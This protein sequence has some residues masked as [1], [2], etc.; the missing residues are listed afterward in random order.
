MTKQWVQQER[1]A[2]FMVKLM[3]WLAFKLGRGGVRWILYPT[4]LYFLLTAPRSVRASRRCLNRLLGRRATLLDV[5]RH[6]F[7]FSSCT[8][9]RIFLLSN[10]LSAFTVE[11][12]SSPGMQETIA[13]TPGCLLIVA[14]F[15]ST[16][17]LR[18]APLKTSVYC[19]P[20]SVAH[21]DQSSASTVESLQVSVLIDK[22]S[23]PQITAQLEA[24]NPA[25]A[26]NLI[27]ASERGPPLVLKLKEALEAGRLVGIAADR[28]N[29]GERAFD[30]QFMGGTA[31]MPDG[32]WVLAAALRVPVILGFGIY[33]GGA[34]YET[35]FELF[36]E[37][38]LL[39]RQNRHEALQAVIQQYALRLEHYVKLAPYNWFNFYDYWNEDAAPAA[40]AEIKA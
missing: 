9:D 4:V 20:S 36:S 15:G 33:R 11:A 13:R 19:M 25:L 2:P 7:T 22:K 10:Q 32:P 26:A 14:H 6:F 34:H 28:T 16:E 27:D 23:S 18:L 17:A 35:H 21:G 30:V 39:P 29:P 8:Q 12:F 37:R 40:S 31:S 38:I 24:I 3:L 5:A 1:G